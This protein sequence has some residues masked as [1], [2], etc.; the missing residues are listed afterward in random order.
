MARPGCSAAAGESKPHCTHCKL[1]SFTFFQCLVQRENTVNTVVTLNI[2][3]KTQC[4]HHTTYTVHCKSLNASQPRRSFLLSDFCTT[5][6]QPSLDLLYSWTFSS[7]LFC[8]LILF[9]VFS[10]KNRRATNAELFLLKQLSDP[11][12]TSEF[13]H[14]RL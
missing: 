11:P 4:T 14:K 7:T 13:S 9:C 6:S 1:C 8:F 2:F 5:V 3:Q 10:A 12:P